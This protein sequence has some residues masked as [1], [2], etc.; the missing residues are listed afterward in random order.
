MKFFKLLLLFAVPV[1]GIAQVNLSDIQD[2]HNSMNASNYLPTYLGD[3]V[4]KFGISLMNT[5]ASLG[6]SFSTFQDAKAYLTSDQITSDMVANSISKLD[7]NDNMVSASVDIA[8]INFCFNIGS[9]GK[10]P[11]ATLGFGINQRLEVN[12]VFNDNLLVLAYQGNKQFAGQTINIIPRFNGIAFTE[13]YVAAASDFELGNTGIT[14]RPAVKLSY[15]SGQGNVNMS[16]DN[17][18][19]LYT[20][21][22]GRYLDFGYNY[23]INASLGNDS[24][25]LEGNTFNINDKNYKIGAGSGL[26]VDFA[27]RISPMKNLSFNLGI[28]DVGSI[29]FNKQVVNMYNHSSYR[30]EGQE[31]TFSENQNI[32]LDSLANIAKPNYSYDAYSAKLPTRLIFSANYGM[33]YVPGKKEGYYKHQFSAIYLQGFDNY[34]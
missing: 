8:L 7:R 18:I 11:A 30:Y 28:M 2:S 16:R 4:N 6:S 5:Y 1:S 34:L 29:R 32:S 25:K 26:G 27:V 19:S 21:P 3:H 10:K 17:S 13:Y 24:L 22:Q 15:L 33:G 12:S 14:I 23:S 9:K 31:L 20:E